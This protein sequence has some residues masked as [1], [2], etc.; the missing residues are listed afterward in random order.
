MGIQEK[1]AM[2]LVV[3]AGPYIGSGLG[4]RLAIGILFPI[5]FYYKLLNIIKFACMNARMNV[6]V[7]GDWRTGG[8]GA[9]DGHWRWSIGGQ[10]DK[11]GNDEV[12]KM[13]VRF[14][15]VDKL[16]EVDIWDKMII[17]S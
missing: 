14:G 13:I 12:G 5:L 7:L 10:V 11:L 9:W 2:H 17:W 16:G 8:Q 1:S 15:Q 6:W 4:L 3:S